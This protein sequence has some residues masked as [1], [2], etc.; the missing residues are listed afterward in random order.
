MDLWAQNVSIEFPGLF[1]KTQ[2][3]AF[4]KYLF[5]ILL[6]SCLRLAFLMSAAWKMKRYEVALIYF[7]QNRSK[8]GMS[9]EYTRGKDLFFNVASGLLLLSCLFDIFHYCQND[10]TE[11][12]SSGWNAGHLIMMCVSPKSGILNLMSL[13]WLGFMSVTSS[14]GV[15]SLSLVRK[16]TL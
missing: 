8:N 3:T 10:Y 11:S 9:K 5:V 1:S 12:F 13:F 2:R 14:F 7:G 4:L 16:S 6:S 15:L